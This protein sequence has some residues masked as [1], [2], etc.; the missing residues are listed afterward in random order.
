[1]ADDFAFSS[2]AGD[3]HINKSTYKAQCWES[4][5]G[6]I[7]RFEIESLSSKGAE[8][9]VKY[10]CWTKAGKQFR[11]I[12]YFRF[13]DGKIEALECYFGAVAGYPTAADANKKG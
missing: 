13:K 6:R 2:A 7:G 10:V 8:S 12:E 11:N 4:Q 5:K 1:M 3:D 9:F